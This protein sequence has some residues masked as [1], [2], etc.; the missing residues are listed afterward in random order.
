MVSFVWDFAVEVWSFFFFKIF[1]LVHVCMHVHVCM[2]ACVCTLYVCGYPW[3]L[4]DCAGSFGAE[5][6]GN[7]DQFVV[8]TGN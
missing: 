3:R 5:G 2:C 4:E 1:C 6:T 8:D 7:Y